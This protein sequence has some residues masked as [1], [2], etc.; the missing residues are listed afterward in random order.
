MS[1]SLET[2]KEL[3]A[4]I[5]DSL[6]LSL[7]KYV[8]A[9]KY[10]TIHPLDYLIPKERKIRSIV[11]GLETSMGTTV[12]EPIAKSIASYNGFEVL[13]EKILKP[14]PMPPELASELAALISL[15]ESKSTWVS[16]DECISRLRTVS[17]KLDSLRES[18]RYIAPPA[19][20]GVDI[21][22]KKDGVHYAFDTK[23]VQPNVGAIKGFNKQ[24]LEWYAYSIFRNPEIDIKCAI[25]YPYNPFK[26]DFWSH[27][28]H[29]LGVMQPNV[30][31]FV[32][33][34]FWD[35]LS[36]EEY[37]YE[38]I[39]KILIE[40]NEEGLGDELSELISKINSPLE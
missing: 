6:R 34:E 18:V 30:D 37:T 14:D 25:A 31:A 20:T 1:K 21:F 28:P 36:G 23:T 4:K 7:V 32:E 10:G 24:I 35:F 11:G 38:T 40:L 13:S 9:F 29:T 3:E 15:R 39:K 16:A 12:W 27:T 33:N 8:K 26:N 2:S 17:K 22:F 19:G 5:K